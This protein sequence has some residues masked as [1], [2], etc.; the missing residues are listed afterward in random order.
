M[1]SETGSSPVNW[2]HYGEDG[3]SYRRDD[4][5]DVTFLIEGPYLA[6]I[7]RASAEEPLAEALNEMLSERISQSLRGETPTATVDASAL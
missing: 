3:T 1:A 4:G 2:E 5:T 7:S 6:V